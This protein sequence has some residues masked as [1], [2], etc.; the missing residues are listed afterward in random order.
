VREAHEAAN[1]SH[2]VPTSGFVRGCRGR[3]L[4]DGY[5]VGE[6]I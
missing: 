4:P 3:K 5:L 6:G 1:L 2:S